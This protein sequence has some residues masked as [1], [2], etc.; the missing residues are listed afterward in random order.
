MS[1]VYHILFLD[2]LKG[3]FMSSTISR[4]FDRFPYLSA[5]VTAPTR[6]D[7]PQVV[8]AAFNTVDDGVASDYAQHLQQRARHWS[9]GGG[10]ATDTDFAASIR[11]VKRMVQAVSATSLILQD[12]DALLVERPGYEIEKKRRG[13]IGMLLDRA[14]VEW[15][16]LSQRERNAVA[17]LALLG[18]APLQLELV[19]YLDVAAVPRVIG[20]MLSR[21]EGVI[22]R[23]PVDQLPA[24]LGI[25]TSPGSARA[26]G[27]AISVLV[28]LADFYGIEHRALA[29]ADLVRTTIPGGTRPRIYVPP[30][31]MA[32]DEAARLAAKQVFDRHDNVAEGLSSFLGMIWR[33]FADEAFVVLHRGGEVSA[34]GL[35]GGCIYAYR[36]LV[37]ESG[38]EPRLRNEGVATFLGTAGPFV[39]HPWRRAPNKLRYD[40]GTPALESFRRSVM[41]GERLPEVAR[42]REGTDGIIANAAGK[43]F[44]RQIN[45][46]MSSVLNGRMERISADEWAPFMCRDQHGAVYNPGH[47]LAGVG[48]MFRTL[49][50]HGGRFSQFRSWREVDGTHGFD[51]M[52]QFLGYRAALV[53]FLKRTAPLP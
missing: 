23:A 6:A 5:D 47:A 38:A 32:V 10:P 35:I 41:E 2:E 4:I 20:R 51:D 3:C 49:L 46:N 29:A 7:H 25:P 21:L 12:G 52:R 26:I 42:E 1:D 48:E 50:H 40:G 39:D 27:D 16:R 53:D 45:Y 36:A 30:S 43:L 37:D 11:G 18:I 34:Y 15:D 24:I 8:Y 22:A 14:E 31:A 33:E 44:N 9:D 17:N 28:V 13:E 19:N